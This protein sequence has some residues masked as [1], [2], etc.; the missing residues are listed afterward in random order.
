M[1]TKLDIINSMVGST[2]ARLFNAEQRKHP[3]YMKADG[4]LSRIELSVQSMGM[5]FNTEVRVIQKQANGELLV[6]QDCIKADPTDRIADGRIRG[7]QGRDLGDAFKS[8]KHTDLTAAGDE[9]DPDALYAAFEKIVV[10]MQEED[11]DTD[12]CA[13]FIRPRQHAVLLNNDKL[14]DREFSRD[15][16]DFADGVVKT[17]MGVPLVQTNRL[18]DTNIDLSI[19]SDGAEYVPV[20][21]ELDAV[22][23]VMHP[24]T[25]LGGETIP[26]TSNVHYNDLR[27]AWY[28]D[29]Y[30]SFGAAPRRPDQ[31]GAVF[32]FQP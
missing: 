28:I 27:L 25:L 30:L 31:T 16:G 4:T 17:L 10:N 14:I 7:N 9:L 21:K 20:G 5:W 26:L 22:G 23:L 11:A 24:S 13:I 29:S 6:P 12:E 8:G 1:Y 18:V 15:N 2:G 3:L 19:L 32:K